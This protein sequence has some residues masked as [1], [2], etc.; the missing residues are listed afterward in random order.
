[1]SCGIS[2]LKRASEPRSERLRKITLGRPSCKAGRHGK[3]P[4]RRLSGPGMLIIGIWKPEIKNFLEIK[5]EDGQNQ[6]PS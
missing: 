4:G 2:A 6:P 3:I 1:M 5:I